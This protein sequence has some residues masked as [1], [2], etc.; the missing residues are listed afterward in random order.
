MLGTNVNTTLYGCLSRKGLYSGYVSFGGTKNTPVY[1]VSRKKPPEQF[2]G[3][4]VA[5]ITS[6]RGSRMI[7]SPPGECFYQSKLREL[8]NRSGVIKGEFELRCLYE[9]SCGAVIYWRDGEAL[10]VL[11][12]RNKNG[13]Y[14]SFPK[15]HMEVGETE[16]QTAL[17]EVREETGLNVR[18]LSGYRQLS[19][20]SPFGNIKKRVV[21]FLAESKTGAVHIQRSEIDSYCWASFEQ[22]QRMCSY[23]N[24]RRILDAALREILSSS[25]KPKK[26]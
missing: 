21:F 24:D 22:A 16:H 2:M 18:I 5:K 13:R 6:A 7:V 20:Y 10:K 9:K 25:K 26:N 3:T 19:D 12:V 15:G 1:I 11:L 23:Q 17:R 8:I 4:V 14:W